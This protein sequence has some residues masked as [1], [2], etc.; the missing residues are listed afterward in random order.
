[1]RLLRISAII[2][3]FM[4]LFVKYVYSSDQTAG[5]FIELPTSARA[6]GMA[7][8]FTALADDPFGVYYNPAGIS[9]IE[10]PITSFLYQNYILDISGNQAAVTIPG[11]HFSFNIAPAM[12]GAKDEPI[13]D[14]FGNDTGRKFKYDGTVIPFSVAYKIDNF[15][16]GGTAKY[17]KEE[18]GSYSNAVTTYDAG[19]IYKFRSLSFGVSELNLAGK[20]GSYDLPQTLRYGMACSYKNLSLLFDYVSQTNMQK[21]NCAVGGEI[22]VSNF[23]FLRLGY[24]LNDEFGGL[25]YGLGVRMGDF[26]IDYAASNYADLGLT[27]RASLNYCFGREK[28]K[29]VVPKKEE[30]LQPVKKLARGINIAVSEFTAKNT[31]AADASIVT[32]FIRG[33]LVSSRRFN[34]LERANMEMILAEQKFQTSGCTSQECAV[35]MGKILNVKVV[36]I[37]SLSKLM[38]T[39]YIIVSLVNVETGEILQSI[40]EKAMTA[41]E[42]KQA[43][44]QI[45]EKIK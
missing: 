11:K 34:I 21:D 44:H 3:L 29:E 33:E 22:P 36:L 30:P 27:Q 15:S 5:I 45:V 28:V 10:Y 6:G 9:F 8:C 4:T 25:T 14:S 23:L 17:Y 41:D 13:F 39:Y 35:K 40:D 37:G 43:C 42:L 18:I 19:L 7:D 12:I 24:A 1:M 31:S 38:D 16:F 26:D 2:L 20:L 32:D